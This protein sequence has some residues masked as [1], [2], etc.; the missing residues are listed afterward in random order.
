M[1]YRLFGRSVLGIRLLCVAMP[2]IGMMASAQTVSEP[3]LKAAFLYNFAKFVEWPPEIFAGASDS[4]VLC[5]YE[6][7]AVGD[8]LKEIVKGR[9]IN[10]RRL[11]VLEIRNIAASKACQMLFVGA[12]AGRNEDSIL[13]AIGN[14][15]ILV[16]GETRGFAQRGGAINFVLQ[17]DRL[18]FVI[19][20]GATDRARLKLS[21]KL[22]SLA[23]L[24]S[25]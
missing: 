10:G 3:A 9:T 7:N 8:A 12:A 19:N 18:R 24:T 17:D 14:G 21:S 23:I 16:V 11:A 1:D 25:N 22:L 4:M 6:N 13:T 20:L 5:T 15:S 2:L